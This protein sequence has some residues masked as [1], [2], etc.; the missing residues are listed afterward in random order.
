MP[1]QSQNLPRT[2]HFTFMHPTQAT[3][4]CP[5]HTFAQQKTPIPR[6]QRQTQPQQLQCQAEQ[7]EHSKG[8]SLLLSQQP[9]YPG[10]ICTCPPKY[11]GEQNTKWTVVDAMRELEQHRKQPTCQC[12]SNVVTKAPLKAPI[13]EP[14]N[15]DVAD[16]FDWNEFIDFGSEQ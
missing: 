8:T 5:F 1:S 9:K 11:I 10:L 4:D 6:N 12:Q 14:K 7:Y 3:I 15:E 2:P 16:S 13:Y